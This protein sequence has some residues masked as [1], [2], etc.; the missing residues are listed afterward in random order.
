METGVVED[1]GR[2]GDGFIHDVGTPAS[3]LTGTMKKR[4]ARATTR[5]A[6]RRITRM[7]FPNAELPTC[8]FTEDKV[9]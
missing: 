3:S 4:D 2:N 5:A 1:R 7:G 8:F 9:I 6:G